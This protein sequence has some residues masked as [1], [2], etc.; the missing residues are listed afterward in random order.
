MI[1]YGRDLSPF[2]RRVAIWC[3]LQGREV[4]RQPILVQGEDFER[5]KAMN[6]VGRVPVLELDDGTRL[7]ETFAICDWLEETAPKPVRLMPAEGI[8]RRNCLQRIAIANATAEKGV[9]LV[10]DRNRR[11][12][13]LHWKEWQQRLVGQIRGG[14]AALDAAVP[15]EGWMGGERL[16]ASDIAAAIAYQF[17]EVS[18]PWILD[19]GPD[20]APAR[21]AAFTARLSDALPAFAETKPQV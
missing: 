20:P 17:V 13:E 3:A 14:L 19:P 7:I 2:V 21:L 8:A 9:A 6:P 12:E 15:D 18:N 16:D 11:P 5:L 10:Y 1:L 4:E